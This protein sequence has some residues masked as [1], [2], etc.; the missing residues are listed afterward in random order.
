MKKM[1]K[2]S[3]CWLIAM[4]LFGIAGTSNAATYSATYTSGE[5]FSSPFHT[6]E[7]WEFDLT[8][9][10]FDPTVQSVDS[11]RIGLYFADDSR[12]DSSES[13]YLYYGSERET[14]NIAD[15]RVGWFYSV[16]LSDFTDLE[17]D[18]LMQ[19][20]LELRSGDFYFQSATLRAESAVV[21]EP[22]TALLLGLGLMGVAASKKRQRDS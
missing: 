22:S 18:G 3:A 9:D 8:L 16:T 19:M 1:M 21:P 2:L 12:S 4:C 17:D 11:A 7:A 20:S 13:A 14:I 15:N 10:G 5:L 6:S